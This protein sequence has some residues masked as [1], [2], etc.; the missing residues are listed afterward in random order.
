MA[1]DM[2]RFIKPMAVAVT[3][4]TF[5]L[6]APAFAQ[7][8]HLGTWKEDFA[9]YK[10]SPAPTTPLP[11]S[12]LR[13]YEKFGDG[14]TNTGVTLGADG[15]MTAFAYSAHFDGKDYPYFGNPTVDTIQLKRINA[16]TMEFITKKAGK[17]GT[18]GRN[19]ISPD[20]KT[21]TISQKGTNAQGQPATSTAVFDRQ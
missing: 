3:L 5:G 4:F 18:T 7:D 15:K 13:V 1:N 19:T 8:A 20:G 9:K 10:S 21:M 16:S 14:L 12:V 2:L 6:A 17:V 11:S